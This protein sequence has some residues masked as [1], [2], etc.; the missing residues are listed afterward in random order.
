MWIAHPY[1][2]I[3]DAESIG[4]NSVVYIVQLSVPQVKDAQQLAI[5]YHWM[6]MLQLLGMLRWAIM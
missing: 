6:Q 4:K 3:L 5:M 2:T 1:A